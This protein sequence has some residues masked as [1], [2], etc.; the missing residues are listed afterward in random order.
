ME[1]KYRIRFSAFFVFCFLSSIIFQL[2]GAKNILFDVYKW[3]IVQPESVQGG[4]ELV[5]LFLFLSFCA[6]K[7]DHKGLFL[8]IIL[9]STG[10]Y[11]RLHQVLEPAVAALFYFEIII[12]FGGTVRR[13]VG[14]SKRN[15]IIDYFDSCVI[16]LSF[17]GFFAIFLSLLGHGTFHELRMLT[18]LILLFCII[19]GS[20]R[21]WDYPLSFK[22]AMKI[23]NSGKVERVGGIF[24]LILVLV[25]FAKSN[26]AIDYDSI[27][28]GLR[29]EYVLMG[30]HS[31]F[32]NLGLVQFVH[33]YPKLFELFLLPISNLG[34]Y[35]FIYAGTILFFALLLLVVCAF[36]KSLG[37][38]TVEGIYITIL[39]GTIP[40][41]SN[42]ASTAKTDMFTA[43]L[44]ILSTYY[45]WLF[46][47]DRFELH[48][49]IFSFMSAFLSFGGKLSSLVYMP[50]ILLG[51][52]I[53]LT[54]GIYRGLEIKKLL[55]ACIGQIKTSYMFICAITILTVLGIHYR[56]YIL[57]G[58]PIYSILGGLWMKLGFEIKY[59]LAKNVEAIAGER[60]NILEVMRH[61]YRLLFNPGGYSHYVMVWPGNISFYLFILVL[62][63]VIFRKI[64]IKSYLQYMVIF[65]PVVLTGVY[66]QTFFPEGGDG[67]YYIVPVILSILMYLYPIIH[68]HNKKIKSAVYMGVAFFIPFQVTLMFVSHW[69]WSWGTASFDYKLNKPFLESSDTVKT[70]LFNNGLGEI[71]SYIEEKSNA[72]AG[73]KKCLAFGVDPTLV[74]KLPC[75]S[76]SL[77]ISR[78]RLG[79]PELFTSETEIMKYIIWDKI[80]YL[81]APK[82]QM[83]G[84]EAIS[85]VYNLL[86]KQQGVVK[87]SSQEFYLLD[88]SRI[89]REFLGVMFK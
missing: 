33:Y 45:L 10:L 73:V 65:F 72:D 70:E 41:I 52:A 38:T 37:A 84:Y 81:I 26:R 11:L 15:K 54:I 68:T 58:Y 25:Q 75:R 88:I 63:L 23:M 18:V 6:S 62:V 82:K 28:Y 35:S 44:I 53:H 3:H 31:I 77:D 47:R 79:N 12:F 86:E 16:G 30:N 21:G 69:S 60:E 29:P 64:P 1:G 4:I 39:I 36:L 13:L 34:D 71:R 17:W 40:G 46:I 32:E 19:S 24:L 59:P 80:D 89:K 5:V 49:L 42:M 9:I 50:M 14:I 7:L 20:F 83:K 56:T 43:F 2:I 8:F 51:F 74:H 61:W 48:Y 87:I 85:N 55:R 76:E 27:W 78:V 57:T 22:I 66:Y 67:N